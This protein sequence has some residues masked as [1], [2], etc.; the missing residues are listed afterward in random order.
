MS[1]KIS[2]RLNKI[3]FELPQETKTCPQTVTKKTPELLQ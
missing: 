3:I 1:S 2:E